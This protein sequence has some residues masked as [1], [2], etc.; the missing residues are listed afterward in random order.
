MATPL[1]DEEEQRY[2][3]LID[4]ILE[5]ADLLTV[6]RKK[7]RKGLEKALGGK[8][9]SEQK[10]AIKALIE[11]RF[12]AINSQSLSTP[13]LHNVS[14]IDDELGSVTPSKRRH[15]TESDNE[16]DD[17]SSRAA[18]EEINVA[19]DEMPAK[20]K[21]KR[22]SLSIED[23]DARL[24]AE[25]QAQENRLARG[26]TTRGGSSVVK[27]RKKPPSKKKSAPKV[28]TAGG[29]GSDADS[30]GSGEVK[31]NRKTGGF[32]KPF[33]LSDQLSEL[34][35]SSQVVKK[36]WVYIKAHDLQD[37]LDKRQIRCD[38]KMQAV[39]QQQR[40]GMFQMNKLLGSHLYPVEE[41]E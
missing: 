5:T 38:D 28:K 14:P 25:L 31:E 10:E 35:G 6:T 18:T 2:T 21:H 32:Q 37:P 7:V 8:D 20:K 9:L 34:V 30:D 12:D 15:P 23:A 40:V 11:A 27:P 19:L 41:E 16:H 17:A 39:F 13:P 33:N 1:S 3:H 26:R 24:A 22:S 36:L 29:D 4:A